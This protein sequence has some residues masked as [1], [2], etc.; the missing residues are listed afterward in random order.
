M[1][2]VF[3]LTGPGDSMKYKKMSD[4]FLFHELVLEI[5]KIQKCKKFD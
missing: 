2:K 1:K 3:L 5:S 4:F